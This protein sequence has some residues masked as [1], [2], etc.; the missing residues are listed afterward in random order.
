MKYIKIIIPFTFLLIL[1]SCQ[2]NGID[3]G[4]LQ[5]T[6]PT[7]SHFTENFGN[8][9]AGDFLGKIIDKNM[10]PISSVAITIG[11]SVAITDTN[12]VFIIKDAIVYERFA[13]VKANKPGYIQGS[14]ALI[15]VN[16]TNKVTIMLLED[17]IVGTVMSSSSETV[18]LTNGA[19][20][21]LNGAYVDENETAYSGAVSVIMHHLDPSDS[22]MQF[23]M[24]GM[25]YAED[26]SF[27]ENILES[28]GMLA[29]ELRGSNGEKLNIATNS[30]AEI[31]IP[32]DASL[33]P[34]APSTIPLW[35]FD[36]EA[37]YWKEEGQATLVGNTYI[38][39]VSHFSFWNTDANFPAVNLCINVTDENGNAITNQLITLTHSNTNYPY[40]TS[41]G[42]SNEDGQVCGLIPSNETLVLNAY[43]YDIC[44]SNIIFTL[45]IGPFAIDSEIDI[46]IPNNNDIISETVIGNF[47]NCNGDAIT[48]GYVQLTYGNQTFIDIV[49]NG[50]FEISL[51]RCVDETS[52]TIQ[53]FDYDN[54]QTIGVIN[55]TF[56]TPLTDLG[57][58]TSCNTITEFIQ[59]SI[60]DGATEEVF[61]F[62]NFSADF[63]AT[64]YLTNGPKIS[65]FGGGTNCFYL[66]AYINDAPYV[67]TYDFFDYSAVNILDERGFIFSECP[68]IS[69]TNN[70]IIYN[71]T[72][73]GNVGEYIDVNFSGSYEGFYGDSHTITGVIHVI[74]DN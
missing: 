4:G 17:T 45:N 68:D 25:L 46:V 20:V 7:E 41:Y 54:L 27:E 66:K 34:S 47:S 57:N 69:N 16:G 50:I 37:G 43:K 30:T 39:S 48:N 5:T 38:G 12:G 36:E 26:T 70:N 33:I 61:I 62:D 6:T 14:R 32:L 28:Y 55:Y 59:Y 65:I 29:V 22:T 60:D 44:G 72:S 31:S 64:N 42:Y 51:L 11:N 40:P 1:L 2:E 15:P 56:S 21:T 49:E 58:L 71:L 8:E 52:F 53:A 23:Q 74:R 3:T 67:G 35:Y 73:L 63:L 19:S 18:M 13:F 10:N 24:P 9:I